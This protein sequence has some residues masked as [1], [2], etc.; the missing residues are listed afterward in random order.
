MGGHHDHRHDDEEGQPGFLEQ[1]DHHEAEAHLG[2]AAREISPIQPST[3]TDST[4][5]AM[6]TP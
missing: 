1:V 3:E 4:S 5:M 6:I 2:H